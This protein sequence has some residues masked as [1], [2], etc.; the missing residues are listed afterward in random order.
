MADESTKKHRQELLKDEI[1]KQEEIIK[2]LKLEE[3]TEDVQQQVLIYLHIICD[4]I[5]N[6]TLA[7][8]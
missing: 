5:S 6:F 3:Q 7:V 8:L 2:N 4:Y 1:K